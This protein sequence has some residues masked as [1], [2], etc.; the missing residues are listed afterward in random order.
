MDHTNAMKPAIWTIHWNEDLSVGIPEIDQEHQRF[1]SLVNDLNYA[2]AEREEKAEV[3]RRLRLV[4]A[5][6]TTHFEHEERLFAEYGYPD[7]E[8]HAELHAELNRQ[9]L[10]I[11]GEFR[12]SQSS[13]HWIERGLLIKRLL[14]EHLLEEDMKYREF[15]EPRV[16]RRAPSQPDQD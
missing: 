9:L 11:L 4:V 8:R 2:I 13:Y 7:A 12:Q 14:V 1:I 10:H 5:D 16:N 15:M 6:A 3:E